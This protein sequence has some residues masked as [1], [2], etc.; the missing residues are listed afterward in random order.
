MW[1]LLGR[2]FAAAILVGAGTAA[3]SAKP[4]EAVGAENFYANVI[5]QIG[6]PYVRVSSILNNPNT[7][8]HSYESDTR[9]ASLVAS[10]DLIV[11]NGVGYDAFMQK[12][13]AASPHPGRAVID[14]GASLGLHAGDNPHLWYRPQTMPFVAGAIATALERLDP[15]HRAVFEANRA[16]FVRSLQ[17]WLT[18]IAL[19]RKRY[20]GTP[21]AV[22]EPV[23]NYTAEAIGLDIKTPRSFQLAIEEG[24]DPAPQD[25]SAVRTLLSGR[26]VRMFV[27]NQ[28][29]VEPTTVQLLEVAR[30]ARVPVVGVYETM[31]E[32]QT[33]QSW[34]LAE[35]Q[36]VWRALRNG[37]ST[38]HVY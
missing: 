27:Y 2:L 12:L 22:T 16:R 3:A 34:M 5:A 23:F 13:E 32:G 31:P 24:N 20:A 10:A 26:E 29:T 1:K 33:Y 19:L 9:D 8:P 18:Q 35:V 11:Q 38:E 4:L 36:A 21:I 15:A 7:D 14:V 17:P 28:Q 30:S 25:V 37:T 6:G